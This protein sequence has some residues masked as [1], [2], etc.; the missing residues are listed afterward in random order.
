[1]LTGNPIRLIAFKGAL[2]ATNSPTP[3]PKRASAGS[4]GIPGPVTR[5]W[6]VARNSTE[7]GHQNSLR[8]C[9]RQTRQCRRVRRPGCKP[10]GIV[11]WRK[12]SLTAAVFLVDTREEADE[13]ASASRPARGLRY[14]AR[15]LAAHSGWNHDR[16]D[17]VLTTFADRFGG[18]PALLAAHRG[19]NLI[20][21]HRLQRRLRAARRQ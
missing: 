6:V 15:Y 17:T 13:L 1:M 10:A 14:S 2:T 19:V 3:G 5:V 16:K 4:L 8:W 20:G 7:T 9:A 12:S 11:C 18:Q 21:E